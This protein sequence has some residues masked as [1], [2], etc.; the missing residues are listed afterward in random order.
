MTAAHSEK[1][2]YVL[3]EPVRILVVDDDPI[4]REFS[5]VYL[6][7]PHAEVMTAVSA[8]H[9][10]QRLRNKTFD[11]LLVDYEMPGMNGVEF[12]EALRADDRYADLPVI[13][14][15]SHEDIATI[16]A[17][18]RAGATSFATK[19]VNWRLLNYHIRYVFRAQKVLKERIAHA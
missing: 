18:Y 8:E 3:D 16:D 12:V 7:S 2:S 19:P 1:H 10:F 4:Q 15:T 9:A 11:I 6:S 5:S 14:V 17:A 13:M